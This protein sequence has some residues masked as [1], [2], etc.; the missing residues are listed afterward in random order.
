MNDL[1][2]MK[3]RWNSKK[4]PTYH[5]FE[6]FVDELI[7]SPY[8]MS[9]VFEAHSINP[10]DSSRIKRMAVKYKAT[11]EDKWDEKALEGKKLG[12]QKS[13]RLSITD[14]PE[15]NYFGGFHGKDLPGYSVSDGVKDY[16]PGTGGDPSYGLDKVN[17][18]PPAGDKYSGNLITCPKPGE[19]IG[20]VYDEK[21]GYLKA[22]E[23]D[24][25]SRKKL[26]VY[27]LAG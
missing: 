26:S 3:P 21:H 2:Y 4:F 18:V 23:H 22:E 8:S 17:G 16:M 7:N 6:R 1:V 10:A 19:M 14:F 11:T 27:P 9:E 25:L 5:H 12:G 13:R 20:Q 24:I 15:R